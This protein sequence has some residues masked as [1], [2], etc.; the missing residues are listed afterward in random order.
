VCLIN[1]AFFIYT[2]FDD[3]RVLLASPLAGSYQAYRQR[4]G[5][6]VPRFN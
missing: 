5:M 1:I 2:A 6:I 3:E 4:V